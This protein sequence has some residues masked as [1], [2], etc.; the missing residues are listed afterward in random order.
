MTFFSV[1]IATQGLHRRPSLRRTLKCLQNQTFRDF[2]VITDDS[3]PNEY[4]ARNKAAEKAVGK[5][6]AF[7]DD[8]TE[9]P[10]HWLEKAYNHLKGGEA[11]ILTGSLSGDFWGWGQRLRISYPFWGVGANLFI[12]RDVFLENGGFE[13]G[14][15]LER[16]PR[17]WRSDTEILYRLIDRYGYGGYI[18][19]DDVQMEHPGPMGSSWVPYVEMRF[20]KRHRKYVLRY[21]APYDPRLC[22]FVVMNG[23][24]DDPRVIRYLSHDQKPRLDWVRQNIHLLDYQLRGKTRILDVGGE[25]GFLFAGTGWDYTVVDLDEYEVPDGGFVHHDADKP[26][27]F[28]DSSFDVVVLGEVLEHVEKPEHVWK[29]ACRVARHMVLATIP[30]EYEW[31][32]SKAPLITREERMAR[33]GF[34]DVENMARHFTSKSPFCKRVFSEKEKPHLWHVRWFRRDDVERLVGEAEVGE[35]KFGGWSWFTVKWVKNA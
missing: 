35:L 26:W 2:E 25:D 16:P 29:E 22:Q 5:Y 28:E 21:I 27:P 8:D 3:G 12:R 31:D 9:P 17:G 18:H 10:P 11:V 32:E 30:N 7:C 4:A 13:V 6:L 33:D 19:A 23:L 14:W 20:Y 1:I 24:D 34:K 15:G